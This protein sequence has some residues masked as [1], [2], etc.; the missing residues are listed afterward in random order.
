ML[1][2][3]KRMSLLIVAV[4]AM[5]LAIV[6]VAFTLSTGWPTSNNSGQVI[7]SSKVNLPSECEKPRNGYLI[8]MSIT[9]FNDSIPHGA[10]QK[11]WPIITVHKGDNVTLVVC[12]IDTQAHGFQVTHYLESNIETVRPGQ[13]IRI[14]FVADESGTFNMY[15]SIFCS[16]HVYMQNS[17]LEV[18]AR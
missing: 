12:N 9:G 7:T 8:I 11:P 4:V 14:P 1:K 15:C 13:V 17:K 2:Q 6:F 5:I 10:P 3:K 18:V 16:I